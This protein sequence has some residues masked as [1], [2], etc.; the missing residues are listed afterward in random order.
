MIL[1][2]GAFG[3]L[4]AIAASLAAVSVANLPPTHAPTSRDVYRTLGDPPSPGAGQL[5]VVFD[6]ACPEGRMRAALARARA[7][8]VDGPTATGAYVLRVPQGGREAALAALRASPDVQLAQSL[9]GQ[10]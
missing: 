7:R 9:G 2:A 3:A 6:P 8:I 5:V 4:G 10:G 1:A